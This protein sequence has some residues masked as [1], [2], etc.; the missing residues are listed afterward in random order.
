MKK[1]FL[2]VL[3]I[4]FL[5]NAQDLESRVSDLEKRVKMLEEKLNRLEQA[6][7]QN[8]N[9]V[10]KEVIPENAI[11]FS[12]LEKKFKK[13]DNQ[14]DRNDYI[15][16]K[17]VVINNTNKTLKAIDGVLKIYDSSGKELISKNIRIEKGMLNLTGTKIKPAEKLERIIEIVYD[18]DKE[19]YKIVK[20]TPL[21]QLKI[22]F[23]PISLEE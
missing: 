9:I 8:V 11:S 13:S 3:S 22:E 5:A 23:I 1:I 18:E 12:V 21:N 15:V 16:L 6:P 10:K 20:D 2:S 14:F 19:G 7:A 17:A 4:T